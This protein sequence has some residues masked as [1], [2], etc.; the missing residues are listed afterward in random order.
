MAAQRGADPKR[1]R[2][3]SVAYG[4]LLTGIAAAIGF[5]LLTR[6]PFE[7]SVTRAPGTLYTVDP[8]GYVRNT[9]L[10][11]VANS[12][13][14]DNE[15]AFAVNIEGIP[16]AE[17][18]VADVGLASTESRVVPLVVRVP[19]NATGERTMPLRVRVSASDLGERVLD[20]TF[21]A[22]GN[23]DSGD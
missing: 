4:A 17:L 3:R 15:V 6:I 10:L 18:T 13:A 23:F 5:L 2:P 14:G 8:D 11:R 16:G 21:K 1:V 22:G 20:T 7:A 9:Y 12:A 19:T